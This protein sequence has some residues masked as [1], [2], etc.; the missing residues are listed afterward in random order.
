MTGIDV[1]GHI[2]HPMHVT[3][4]LLGRDV[5]PYASSKF[6]SSLLFKGK[7]PSMEKQRKN[8]KVK[9]KRQQE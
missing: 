3:D 4:A 5:F 9:Q 6:A 2:S 8:G 1:Y 7:R